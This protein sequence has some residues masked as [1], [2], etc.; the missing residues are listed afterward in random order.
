[1]FLQGKECLVPGKLVD[2][3]ILAH[4]LWEFRH[5]A[6][7]RVLKVITDGIRAVAFL[8]I[9]ANAQQVADNISEMIKQQLQ[10]QMEAFNS[11][12]ETMQDASGQN[13]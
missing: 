5:A 12:V 1:M 13:G 11:N 8:I 2:L 9:D 7:G 10:E 3:Q 6:M 4:I